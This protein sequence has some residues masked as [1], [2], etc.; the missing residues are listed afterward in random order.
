MADGTG[1]AVQHGL[2]LFVSVHMG[3]RPV[4]RM[5]L[6]LVMAMRLV[7]RMSQGL[8]FTVHAEITSL[9]PYIVH[10]ML[11]MVSDTIL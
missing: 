9:I 6:F 7:M 8:I 5:S 2:S 4:M 11:K 1:H 3:M 10:E